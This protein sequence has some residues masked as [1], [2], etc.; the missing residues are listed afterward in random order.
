[1]LNLPGVCQLLHTLPSQ[2]WDQELN[3]DSPEKLQSPSPLPTPP[4]CPGPLLNSKG[5]GKGWVVKGRNTGVDIWAWWLR[6]RS[7]DACVPVRVPGHVFSTS[8]DAW[9]T[10]D[11]SC[12]G[13]PTTPLESP[14][15]LLASTA[16]AVN[17]LLGSEQITCSVSQRKTKG[18]LEGWGKI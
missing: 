5:T 2:G 12:A 9:G 14:A 18:K 7:K 17:R 4:A 8:A 16:R 3:A 1:M 15:E 13:V 11:G 10:G 6:Q